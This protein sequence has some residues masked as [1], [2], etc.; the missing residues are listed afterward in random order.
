MNPSLVERLGAPDTVIGITRATL[1][2]CFRQG[3]SSQATP[4]GSQG[5]DRALARLEALGFDARQLANRLQE[6]A[7]EAFIERWEDLMQTLECKAA[8]PAATLAGRGC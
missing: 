4:L 5:G 7:A 8:V 3:S 2:A 6:E 1:E